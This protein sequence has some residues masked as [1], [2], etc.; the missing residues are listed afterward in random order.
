MRSRLGEAGV[1]CEKN[2]YEKRNMKPGKAVVTDKDDIKTRGVTD[3]VTG[4][5]KS[6]VEAGLDC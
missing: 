5:S 6:I 2:G 3:E 4:S 1:S